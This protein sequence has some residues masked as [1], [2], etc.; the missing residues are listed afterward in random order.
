MSLDGD[1]T[2]DPQLI[3]ALREW[4]RVEAQRKRVPAF[5]IFS[6]RVLLALA[7]ARPSNEDE[8][9]AVKGVGPS[10]ARKYGEPLLRMLSSV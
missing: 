3:D 1:S 9:L 10:L 5:R 4:R 8:L 7:E 6:N 2:A